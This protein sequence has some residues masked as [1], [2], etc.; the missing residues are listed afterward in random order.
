MPTDR[1]GQATKHSAR[2]F[3]LT[4]WEDNKKQLIFSP[5]LVIDDLQDSDIYSW[6]IFSSF[7][8]FS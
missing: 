5:W 3:T 4:F 1:Q 8:F 6:Y 2:I 7:I